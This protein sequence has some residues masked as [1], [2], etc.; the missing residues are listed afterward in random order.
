MPRPRGAFANESSC[1]GRTDADG[2][3]TL[4]NF[5]P[6]AAQVTVRLP[7]SS[8]VRR[9]SVPDNP[10]DVVIGATINRVGAFEVRA[11]T[12]GHQSALAQIVR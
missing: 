8:Y 4:D 7:N 1:G 9:V 10:G 5:P 3:L 12:V 6:G 2:R 11:T